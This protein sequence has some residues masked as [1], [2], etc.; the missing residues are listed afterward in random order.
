MEKQFF[1]FITNTQTLILE[2]NYFLFIKAK[3]SALKMKDT[4]HNMMGPKPV[5]GVFPSSPIHSVLALPD[6]RHSISGGYITPCYLQ[7][8]VGTKII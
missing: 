5:T 1:Q 7:I 8:D 6:L 4:V 2:Y 3:A